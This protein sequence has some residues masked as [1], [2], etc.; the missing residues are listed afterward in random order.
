[1]SDQ[2]KPTGEYKTHHNTCPRGERC[3]CYLTGYTDAEYDHGLSVDSLD[4]PKPRKQD[5][6]SP[7]GEW[8][9]LSL[10]RLIKRD[11]YKGAAGAHNAALAA[12]RERAADMVDVETR[13]CHKNW[14]QTLESERVAFGKEILHLR[15]QLAA[16]AA[17]DAATKQLVDAL[18]P[19]ADH[20]DDIASNRQELVLKDEDFVR[21][22]VALAKVKGAYPLPVGRTK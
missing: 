9:G 7:T 13:R 21:A 6:A 8:T 12:E 16:D 14:K 22:K 18:E 15:E 1:M 2:P 3:A 5:A 20:A 4:Q 19:F 10:S 17:V 11:G